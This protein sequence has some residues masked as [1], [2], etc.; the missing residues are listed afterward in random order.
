MHSPTNKCRGVALGQHW[1][2][3]P[4]TRYLLPLL[5]VL[6]A[7]IAR[8]ADVRS[9]CT[10]DPPHMH[11]LVVVPCRTK[12]QVRRVARALARASGERPSP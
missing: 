6:C 8:C 7:I 12:W 2:G 3:M 9:P 11:V 4:R 1:A 10:F 5:L